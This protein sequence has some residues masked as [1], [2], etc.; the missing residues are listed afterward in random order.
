MKKIFSTLVIMACLLLAVPA[1]AQVKF[2]LKGGIDMSKITT[3]IGDNATGFFAGPMMEVTLPIVGLG[4]D[5]AALYSQSG[6]KFDGNSDKLKSIEV[7]VNLKW[8]VGLGS[9]FGIFAAVGPQFGFNLDNGVDAA[10]NSKTCAV[11]VNAGVGLKLLRHLQLGVNYNIGASEMTAKYADD[12]TKITPNFRKN[13]WQ[14]SLAY[15]F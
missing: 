15:M 12:P 7:P 1:Q 11:S 3:E 5:V 6:I 4:V 13:S 9:T 14:V 2:G 10:L 8:T